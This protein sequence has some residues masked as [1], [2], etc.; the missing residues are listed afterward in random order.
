MCMCAKV[1][2][3]VHVYATHMNVEGGKVHAY[4]CVCWGGA[5]AYMCMCVCLG[6]GGGRCG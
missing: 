6:G 3:G 4:V 5:H 1:C 2:K